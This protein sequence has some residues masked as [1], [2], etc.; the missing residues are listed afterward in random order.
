MSSGVTRALS[1]RAG[2]PLY[3]G[4]SNSGAISV[5]TANCMACPR[6]NWISSTSGRPTTL[7]LCSSMALRKPSLRSFFL[8]FLLDFLLEP[9]GHHVLGGLAGPEAGQPG[10][11]LEA[12]GDFREHGFNFFRFDFHPQ[13]FF[14]RPQIFNGHIHKQ[15]FHSSGGRI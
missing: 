6:A 9:F 7:N 15:P 10:L 12:G 2:S 14:A 1:R 4:S 5:V 11:V 13:Q 8:G 3:S